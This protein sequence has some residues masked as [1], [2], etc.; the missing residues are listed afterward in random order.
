MTIWKKTSN[1]FDETLVE[2]TS[3]TCTQGSNM[4]NKNALHT[5]LLVGGARWEALWNGAWLMVVSRSHKRD[6]LG[7]GNIA[8]TIAM[9]KL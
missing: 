9:R 3:R 5:P 6:Q 4:N 1:E 8:V 2:T 7:L